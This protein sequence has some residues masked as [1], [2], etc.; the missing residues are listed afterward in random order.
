MAHTHDRTSFRAEIARNNRATIG[1]IVVVVIVLYAVLFFAGVLLGAPPVTTLVIG[2]VVTAVYI[3]ATWSFSV[4]GVLAAARARPARP[5]VREEKLLLHRVEEMS[6][7]AGMPMP[8]V[9]VQESRDINAFATGLTPKNS[10]ICVTTGALQLLDQ[11]ELE[12][13]IAHEMSHILNQDVRV[14]TLTVA[15]VGAIAMVAEIVLRVLWYGGGGRGKKGAPAPLIIVG[16]ILMILAPILTRLV[17]FALSRRREYLAD[18]SGVRLT[19]N[20]E[21]LARALEKIRGDLPDHPV[22]SKTVAG[23][24]IANPWVRRDLSS[25]WSTHPPINERIRRIRGMGAP[26]GV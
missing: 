6:I 8:K 20:P 24:Y 4:Q 18:A 25:A 3:A 1:L 11:E 13:V 16:L 2:S 22:G 19:R 12:G 17:Y 23:L 9:Y 7:A 14:T 10:V 5:A 21:G 15:M 26:S